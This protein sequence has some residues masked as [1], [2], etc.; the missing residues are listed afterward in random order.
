MPAA[1]ASGSQPSLP[2]SPSQPIALGRAGSAYMNVSFDAL[3]DVGWSTASDPAARLQLG[4]HDP[5][6]R[7]FS[8]RNAEIAVDGA[9]DPYFKGQSIFVMKLDNAPR[10]CV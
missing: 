9:V 1:P 7:G 3:A 10:L 4:D 2:W 6:Q 5:I 8:M